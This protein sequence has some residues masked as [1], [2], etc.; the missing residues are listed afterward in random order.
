[1]DPTLPIALSI[2]GSVTASSGFWILMNKFI[3]TKHA[4]KVPTIIF[5]EVFIIVP[6]IEGSIIGCVNI[7]K[8]YT[9]S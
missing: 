3:D 2:F 1:M 5:S 8:N 7:A 4:D 6:F 9:A